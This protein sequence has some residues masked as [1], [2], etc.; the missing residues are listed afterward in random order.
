MNTPSP[1]LRPA[2]RLGTSSGSWSAARPRGIRRAPWTSSPSPAPA[3]PSAFPPATA[4]SNGSLYT[5]ALVADT[6]LL[7]QMRIGTGPDSSSRCAGGGGGGD[8]VGNGAK[9]SA[10]SLQ[11]PSSASVTNGRGQLQVAYGLPAGDTCKVS[12]VASIGKKHGHH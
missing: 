8:G 4:R 12:L 3:R 2:S 11:L 1:R 6:E 5:L 9:P 10:S 7:A